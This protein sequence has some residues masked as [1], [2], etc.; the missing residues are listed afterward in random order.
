[1]LKKSLFNFAN[2]LSQNKKQVIGF[3]WNEVWGRGNGPYMPGAWWVVTL[4][5]PYT[6][7]EFFKEYYDPVWKPGRSGVYY[8]ING[9]GD[10][11]YAVDKCSLETA[12]H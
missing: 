11:W 12:Q 4:A 8:E 2:E 7:S 9:V 10:H 3:R 5:R 1:M 6:C